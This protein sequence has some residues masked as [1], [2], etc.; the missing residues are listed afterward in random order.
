MTE[1]ARASGATTALAAPG[2]RSAPLRLETVVST[3]DGL[4]YAVD[5]VAAGVKGPAQLAWASDGRLFVAEADGRVRV[6][7]P[8]ER[9]PGVMEWRDSADGDRDVRNLA[10]DARALLDPPPVGPMGIAL[11]PEFRQNHFVY[12]AFLA[13]DSRERTALRVIRLR[14]VGGTLGEAA[15][16]F[17]A[18]LAVDAANGEW[19]EAAGPRLAFGPDTFLYVALPPGVEFIAEPAASTPHASMLRVRDDG[20]VPLD[21]PA[22]EGVPASPIGFDWHPRTGML[23]AMFPSEDGD[24]VLRSLTPGGASGVAEAG[25]ATMRIAEDG[26]RESGRG[27]TAAGVLRFERLP[28]SRV[29]SARAFVGLSGSR[30]AHRPDVRRAEPERAPARRDVRAHR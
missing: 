5:I 2:T 4:A 18:P 1:G 27:E 24:V 14:D 15:T 17:E 11:H 19:V 10:L 26:G 29:G 21:L 20:R 25:R 8:G 13:Q 3:S 16:I 12:V 30:R 22:L 9:D 23:W 28:D 7:R 6:I